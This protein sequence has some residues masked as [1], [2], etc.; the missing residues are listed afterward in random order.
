[1]VKSSEILK[2]SVKLFNSLAQRP[3]DVA[4]EKHSLIAKHKGI[5]KDILGKHRPMYVFD[6][7]NK[8]G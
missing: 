2:K 4:F 7:A 6:K 1:L 3:Q 5:K 8:L